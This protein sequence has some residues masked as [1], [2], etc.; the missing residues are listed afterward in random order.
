[1][2]TEWQ[3]PC[4]KNTIYCLA[5]HQAR[6]NFIFLLVLGQKLHEDVKK[7]KHIPCFV[8]AQA[9]VLCVCAPVCVCVVWP[10]SWHSVCDWSH[11]AWCC[12]LL[13]SS[14]WQQRNLSGLCYH[15]NKCSAHKLV[16]PRLISA[17]G[18]WFFF[19]TSIILTSIKP[20]NKCWLHNFVDIE[21]NE[22]ICVY[23]H[24]L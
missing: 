3:S 7:Q 23:I 4:Q 2:C 24:S 5:K 1:M 15:A 9:C 21:N 14:L 13:H 16:C 8:A 12:C 22:A 6:V 11:N 20:G 17:N 19:F 18:S 10:H